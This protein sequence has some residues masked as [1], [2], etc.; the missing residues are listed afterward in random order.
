MELIPST[1][2]ALFTTF[3]ALYQ[4]AYAGAPKFVD[5]YC[6][7]MPSTSTQQLYH[8]IAQIPGMKEWIGERQLN[9]AVLRNYSLIN[10][11]YEDSIR[12]DKFLV[13][14]DQYG[15]FG[16]TVQ[17]FGDSV[18]RWPDEVMAA[19]VEGGTSNLCYDG[20]PF[21]DTSHPVSISDPYAVGLDGVATFSNKLVGA[22]YDIAAAGNAVAAWSLGRA[23][24]ATFVGDAGKVLALQAD[25]L[26]VPP[27]LETAAKIIGQAEITAQVV[28]N[29]AADQNVAA[30]GITNVWRG[31]LK[32]I[33]VN[34][35]LTTNAAYI[36]CSA[37]P[38]KPFVW[39]LRKA[40]VF[41]AL[42][43]PTLP[44]MFERREFIY[45]A[46][47]R[48]NGGYSLPQLCVRLSAS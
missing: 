43:D 9:N 39:Q 27:A 28:K 38:I 22:A 47:S 25:T 41:A 8:W 21:F 20:Q 18:G 1:G 3:N 26:M 19:I 31:T 11:N 5:Q 44:N 48:G 46:E 37:R 33:I 24:M 16:P 7:T 36:M 35:Y 14:D 2:Q 42:V 45:G 29:V 40:P 17:G 6:T 4:G 10:K 34:P 32:N 23:K 13:E 15:A 12:L 30:A